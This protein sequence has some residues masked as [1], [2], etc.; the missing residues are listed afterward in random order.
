LSTGSMTRNRRIEAMRR[1]STDAP[2]RAQDGTSKYPQ[3]RP[4]TTSHQERAACPLYTAIAV[5]GGRWKPMIL[6]RL[7]E[8]PLGFGELQRA[9]P[10]VTAKVLRE[11]LRQMQADGLVSR[12]QLVPARLGVRYRVTPYGRTL[13]PVFIAL[14]RWGVRHL[15]RPDARGGTMV[16]PP[17]AR[18]AAMTT[19][20]SEA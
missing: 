13:D 4:T 17:M 1:D 19:G 18:V 12:E 20:G 2:P 9:M 8:R 7:A 15:A 14:L 16:R 5:I 3:R 11:Q 6:Q 10:R